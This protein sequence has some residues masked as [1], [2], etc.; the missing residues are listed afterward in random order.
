MLN[1]NL[2]FRFHYPGRAILQMCSFIHIHVCHCWRIYLKSESQ[3]AHLIKMGQLVLQVLATQPSFLH[4]DQLVFSN[5]LS[6]KITLY[7]IAFTG[8]DNNPGF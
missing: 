7:F 8:I 5:I 4:Q 3:L 6:S 2:D 1:L